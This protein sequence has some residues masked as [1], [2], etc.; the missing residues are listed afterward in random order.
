MSILV[1]VIII[2]LSKTSG[3]TNMICFQNAPDILAEADDLEAALGEVGGDSED[4]VDKSAAD[5]NYGGMDEIIVC[6]RKDI[7]CID[8]KIAEFDANTSNKK[9]T[10]ASFK[11]FYHRNFVQ[12]LF[13]LQYYIS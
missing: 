12:S 1:G 10:V 3:Q 6:T 2:F 9:I 11:R 13:V 5:K 8:I 7:D 4:D